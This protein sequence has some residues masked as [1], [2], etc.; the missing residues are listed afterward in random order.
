[1]LDGNVK[2][3][4]SRQQ[5]EKLQKASETFGHTFWSSEDFFVKLKLIN[6]GINPCHDIDF[7][8]VSHEQLIQ[9]FR[10]RHTNGFKVKVS[11]HVIT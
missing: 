3:S 8:V 1:M 9:V 6:F 11:E 5:K 2:E 4:M 10:K 7:S